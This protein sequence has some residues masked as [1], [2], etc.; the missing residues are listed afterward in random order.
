MTS[1]L[2]GTIVGTNE[3]DSITPISIEFRA[4]TDRIIII[5]II[6]R[7]RV[8]SS[9]AVRITNENRPFRFVPRPRRR[10]RLFSRVRYRRAILTEQV[11]V[12]RRAY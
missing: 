6:G 2:L 1:P 12:Y 10:R 3:D 8:R 7:R 11:S 5:V 4:E 9:R